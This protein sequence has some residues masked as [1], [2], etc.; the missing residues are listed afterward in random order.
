M[1]SFQNVLWGGLAA[2]LLVVLVAFVWPPILYYAFAAL[3]I[4]FFPLI[5]AMCQGWGTMDDDEEEEGQG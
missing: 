5:I 4:L 1:N 2:L 3:A